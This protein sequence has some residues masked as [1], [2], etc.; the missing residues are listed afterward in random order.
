MARIT[1]AKEDVTK[2]TREKVKAAIG[3]DG[4]SGSGKS[5]AM[6]EI[7]HVLEPNW[8]KVHI[9]DTENRSLSL[10]V[11]TKLQSGNVVGSFYHANMDKS[12]G[13]SPFNYEFFRKDAIEKGCTAAGMDSYTHMWY[14]EGG[15]LAT[16]NAIEA[17]NKTGKYSNKYTAWGHPDVADGKNLIF[18]LI[19]DNKIHVVA[20][21]RIKNDYILK[22]SE[23]G[24]M[25]VEKVGMKQVQSDG[26][27][28]EFDLLFRMIEPAD[29]NKNKP[30]RIKITKSRYDIFTKDEEYDLTREL[31]QSLKEYLEKGT[32][33]TELEEKLRVEL[34]AGLKKRI[35]ADNTIK[36]VIVTKFPGKLIEKDLKTLREINSIVMELEN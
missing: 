21:I 34:A 23:K 1:V 2:A 11:G 5:G 6:L 7:L 19:R 33:K 22:Q 12:T 35:L 9:T 25:T 8:E 32:S 36:Q 15:V 29:A 14:R 27:E 20:T 28:Y 13:Y 3:I 24:G 17:K 10:Y 4:V 16:V 18:D 30:A 31:L 26:L